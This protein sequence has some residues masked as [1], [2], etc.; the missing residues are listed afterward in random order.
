MRVMDSFVTYLSWPGAVGE[1]G[2]GAPKKKERSETKGEKGQGKRHEDNSP[3]LRGARVM[4]RGASGTRRQAFFQSI[5]PASR[6]RV[7]GTG[8][9]KKKRWIL[10]SRDSVRLRPKIHLKGCTVE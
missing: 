5:C 1:R 10:Q 3:P 7:N 6:P 8:P 4:K 2:G 9:M